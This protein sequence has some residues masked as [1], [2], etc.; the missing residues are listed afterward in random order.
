MG[1]HPESNM[2]YLRVQSQAHAI[3]F[4][5]Y[6]NDIGQNI[7][8]KI[9][10]FAIFH[11]ESLDPHK[12]NKPYKKLLLKYPTGQILGIW[13][14]MS[15]LCCSRSF[16]HYSYKIHIYKS[17]QNFYL[18]QKNVPNLPKPKHMLFNLI[19]TLWWIHQRSA[20]NMCQQPKTK[21][22]TYSAL[23]HACLTLKLLT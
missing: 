8:S 13:N 4:L 9:Q 7:R 10:L 22:V 19:E 18:Y 16:H 1:K 12:M 2:V 5:L 3:M 6:I 23:Q 20:G 14:S 17:Y 11:I 21:Q 15:I